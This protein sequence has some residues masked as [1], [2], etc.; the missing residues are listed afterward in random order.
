[1]A[2]YSKPMRKTGKKAGNGKNS[3]PVNPRGSK[4]RKTKFL[5]SKTGAAY[6]KNRST[7][8]LNGRMIDTSISPSITRIEFGLQYFSNV[9]YIAS[10]NDTSRHM[11]QG[12]VDDRA[13]KLLNV[14]GCSVENSYSPYY[15]FREDVGPTHA[16]KG[17]EHIENVNIVD[18][19]FGRLQPETVGLNNSF[20]N[21]N[22]PIY[23]VDDPIPEQNL[24]D[25]ARTRRAKNNCGLIAAHLVNFNLTSKRGTKLRFFYDTEIV[26]NELRNEND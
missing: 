20:P 25:M 18:P 26:T 24:R 5:N 1:M 13:R 17:I 12:L 22:D 3:P 8:H 19:E 10:S 21:K 23:Q 14:M 15:D 7:S 4:Q 6:S 16:K 2:R 11:N 9:K